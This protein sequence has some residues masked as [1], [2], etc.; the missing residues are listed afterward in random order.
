MLKKFAP[1]KSV[2]IDCSAN[3][4]LNGII[5]KSGYVERY[6]IDDFDKSVA[7][8]N[9]AFAKK[10][11][12]IDESCKLTKVDI[13]SFKFSKSKDD[14]MKYAT[15]KDGFVACLRMALHYYGGVI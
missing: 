13:E 9:L 1:D 12:L 8:L 2:F 5:N 7:Q 10:L 4:G 15:K 11:V 3:A 14:N 6:D